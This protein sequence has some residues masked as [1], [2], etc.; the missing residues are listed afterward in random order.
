MKKLFN[1]V[2]T[3]LREYFTD[4]DDN[5]IYLAIPKSFKTKKEQN[6]MIRQSKNFILENTEIK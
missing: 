6:L 1:N 5:V 2:F 3:Y 4:S